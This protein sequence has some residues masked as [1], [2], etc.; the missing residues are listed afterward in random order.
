MESKM[1]Y[2][3]NRQKTYKFTIDFITEKERDDFK[4]SL[5]SIKIKT[6]VPIYEIVQNMM[7]KFKGEK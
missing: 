2:N 4:N 7:I 6:G 3:E 5:H 1:A